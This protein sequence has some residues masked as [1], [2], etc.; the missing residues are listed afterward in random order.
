M[1]LKTPDANWPDE[2]LVRECRAG[3][4]AAW[5]ALLQ[6]YKKLVYSIPVKYQ[7]P[8]E[9]AADVFQGVW[10]DL[11]R[12]LERLERVAGLRCVAGDSSGAALAAA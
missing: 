11:Y 3:D 2:D 8:P 12:D 5:S 6:K 10:V 4:Q 7:L 9:E 1:I